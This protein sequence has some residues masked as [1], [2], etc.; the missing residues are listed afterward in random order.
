MPVITKEA[1][2][3]VIA[4]D[5]TYLKKTLE[6][7]FCPMWM[8]LANPWTI[9]TLEDNNDLH[10]IGF[11]PDFLEAFDVAARSK[12]TIDD[13]RTLASIM[14]MWH[15]SISSLVGFLVPKKV[16]L[17]FSPSSFPKMVVTASFTGYFVMVVPFL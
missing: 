7:A 14:R 1:V 2:E 16:T 11:L 5:T 15:E 9:A 12:S 4:H 3:E 6:C 10:T 13:I 8:F 17:L